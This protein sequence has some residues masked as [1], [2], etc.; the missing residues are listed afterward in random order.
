[1]LTPTPGTWTIL[2]NPSPAI[3]AILV[4][5]AL[6]MGFSKTGL[7]GA[8]ILAIP[9][10]AWVIDARASTGVV[11]P[12]LIAGDIFAVACY[13]RHADW[14]H[15]LRLMP[16]AITGIFIGYCAL[17]KVT[18][19]QLRPII[20]GTILVML[21][22]NAWRDYLHGDRAPIPTHWSFSAVLGL[23]AGITTM[24]ANAAGPIMAIYLLAMRLPKNVF[25]GTGAWY[26]FL[27]NS[28]KVPFSMHLGLINPESLRLNLLL[29]PAIVLGAVTGIYVLPRV[30]EKLF[31]RLV[32]LL[33]AAAA[34]KLLF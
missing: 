10:V 19:G 12:M 27:L 11:L 13:R 18:D 23:T 34:V 22:L 21:G 15:V 16:W 24:M 14:R 25:V 26:F 32:Q 29:L 31:T 30:P 1:M 3:W 17:G 6:L 9:L 7:P 2:H 20:G 33:A 5:A 28:F 4:G 8:G